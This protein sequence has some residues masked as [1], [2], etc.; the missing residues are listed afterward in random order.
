[1]LGAY[2]QRQVSDAAPTDGM[3]YKPFGAFYVTTLD[4]GVLRIGS[5]G[6]TLQELGGTD[7]AWFGV[8]STWDSHADAPVVYLYQPTGRGVM[9]TTNDLTGTVDQSRGL[10]RGTFVSDGSQVRANAGG[11]RFYGAINGALWVGRDANVIR[12]DAVTLKPPVVTVAGSAYDGGF[13]RSGE[14][15]LREYAAARRVAPQ[16]GRL[17]GIV[18]SLNTAIPAG[19]VRVQARVVVPDGA[20]PTV[21]V[22]LSRLGLSAVAPLELVSNGLYEAS[23]E[24]T[25]EG[26]GL[27]ANR[28]LREWR[29]SWPG[30]MPVTVSVCATGRPPAGGIGTFSL[31]RMPEALTLG[32][33][34]WALGLGTTVGKVT[35]TC[36]HDEGDQYKAL[37]QRLT[38]GP[39]VWRAPIG[40]SAVSANI[41][42]YCA[43]TFSIRSLGRA[44][45]DIVVQLTDKP[46]DM[47]PSMTPGLPIV[48]GG[49][50]EGGT[51]TTE[52]RR[53]TIP[54]ADL[55]KGSTTFDPELFNGMVLSGNSATNYT[56]LI[57]DWRFEVS[58]P[59][60]KPVKG[61][62][63]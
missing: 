13:W 21:T 30:S 12:V 10:Y 1:M 38:V 27:A 53:V 42:N 62:T 39:G 28:S 4:K 7:Q 19:P 48:A 60:A 50:V 35:F 20:V 56:Y 49:Y 22:D 57:D 29:E 3:W 2:W 5:N 11:T 8:G 40:H 51:I 43:M 34:H 14:E 15:A 58:G 63:P 26:L 41:A 18:H 31:Y 33:D 45:G 47:E 9:W 59:D 23:F 55:L 54:V 17:S 32:R 16:A 25:P 24:V 44:D 46:P 52:Y 6:G 61:V 36:E 37:H